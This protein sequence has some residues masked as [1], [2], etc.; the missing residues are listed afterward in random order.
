MARAVIVGTPA[1]PGTGLGRALIV[2]PPSPDEPAGV[3][4]AGTGPSPATDEAARLR[5]AFEATAAELTELAE[6]VR[7]GAGDEVAAILDAQ[8][9]IALD[10][11][12]FDSAHDA[13][14]SGA[15]A[16]D[17]VRTAANTLATRLDG[18]EDERF[19]TRA[20]DVRDVGHRVVRRL[21]GGE[22]ERLAHAD[23]TPAV[24]VAEDLAP[25]ATATLE[26]AR[27]A[28]L[29]LAAGAVTGHAAIVARALG[30]PLVLDL[31]VAV[32]G[33]AP[34]SLVLVDGSAGR[35]LVEPD[36]EEVRSLSRSAR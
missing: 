34:G 2:T 9:L 17:A 25:S 23:G 14:A 31:G 33:I 36:A 8:A 1:S 22:S 3:S 12:L 15:H 19:R 10:P 5:A 16:E 4:G 27:V 32:F 21:A 29:A 7:S 35:V 30:L 18:L 6:R 20:A 13:V 26:P 11:A 24:I 28:G